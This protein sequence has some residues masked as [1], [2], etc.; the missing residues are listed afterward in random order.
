MVLGGELRLLGERA[1]C[2]NGFLGLGRKPA[3]C[4]LGREGWWEHLLHSAWHRLGGIKL[5]F[6]VRHD[7]AQSIFGDRTES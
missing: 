7:T 3:D 6:T 4:L 1:L 2:L 5:P